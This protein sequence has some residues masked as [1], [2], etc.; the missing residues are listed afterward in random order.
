MKRAVAKRPSPRTA[1]KKKPPTDAPKQAPRSAPTKNPRGARPAARA[2][3]AQRPQRTLAEQ[4]LGEGVADAFAFERL[5]MEPPPRR[6]GGVRDIGWAEFGVLATEL[7]SEI[8][9]SYHPDVVLGIMNAGV[10]VGGA[11]APPL[12][13]ELVHLHLP[14][15]GEGKLPS[16]KGKRVLVVDD[17]AGSGRTLARAVS[18]AKRARAAEVRTAVLVLRPGGAKP[19]WHAVESEELCVFG[20]DYQFH[21][22]DAPEDEDPGDTGV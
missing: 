21:G 9:E 5:K 20:W 4:P 17:A 12:G 14:G 6:A 11:L 1:P 16:L 13:A 7:A 22:T 15:R 3:T 19:D 8:G 10:F 18:L 2:K